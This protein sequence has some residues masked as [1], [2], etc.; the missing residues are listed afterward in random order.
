MHQ[1]WFGGDYLTVS[2]SRQQL[3]IQLCGRAMN[4]IFLLF[5]GNGCDL[6][7]TMNDRGPGAVIEGDGLRVALFWHLLLGD[8]TS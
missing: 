4:A 6:F 1:R 2:S 8:R 7:P 5:T 3:S